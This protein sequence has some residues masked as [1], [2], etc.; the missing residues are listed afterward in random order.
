MVHVRRDDRSADRPARLGLVVSRAVGNSVVRHRV[1][2]RLRAVM[3]PHVDAAPPGTDFVVRA[4][5]AAAS[6]TSVQLQEAVG[7]CLDRLG[8]RR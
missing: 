3:A 8:L 6:A 1:S 5:P 2:R 4:N 7:Q